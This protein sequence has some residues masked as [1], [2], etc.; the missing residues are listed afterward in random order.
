MT[1]T[2]H[3]TAFG[4]ALG[5]FVAGVPASA[6]DPASA[7]SWRTDYHAARKEAQEK[8]RP[9]YVVIGSDNCIYC[10]KQDATTFRDPHVIALLAKQYVPIRL[11]AGADAAIVEALRVSIYPTSVIAAPE[12][13]I[14]AF[15]P[16]YQTPDQA[17]DHLKKSLAVVEAPARAK[18]LLA[19]AKEEFQSGRYADCLDKC[20]LIS[21][22]FA[23]LPEGKDAVTLASQ[24]KSDPERLT[25]AVD[26]LNE[27]TATLYL[28]LADTWI[29]K[30]RP[31][32]ARN[33][34][35]KVMRLAP[36]GRLLESAKE[37][38]ASLRRG[39]V[40]ATPAVLDKMK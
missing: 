26:Q 9:L 29:K 23:D 35:E 37:K 22:K 1:L 28:T 16:G 11:D 3:R 36:K 19:T 31:D 14:L 32:E 39:G 27:R 6:A 12:G 2:L 24:I 4:L 5:L 7:I 21:V 13:K 30:D 8:G 17:R 25:V 33:V 40:D 20:E 18:E 34:L 38:L 15:L 10:K